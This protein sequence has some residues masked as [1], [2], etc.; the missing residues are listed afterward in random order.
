MGELSEFAQGLSSFLSR[1]RSSLEHSTREKLEQTRLFGRP[2]RADPLSAGFQTN[3]RQG[4]TDEMKT[5]DEIRVLVVDDEEPARKALG[6]ILSAGG[7]SVALAADGS[8]VRH[9]LDSGSFAV[10]VADIRLPGESG[11]DLVRHVLAEY[12]DIAALM[13]TAV[14]DPGMAEIA[15]AAGAY[16]YLVKPFKQTELLINVANAVRRRTLE[17][18]NRRHLDQLEAAVHERTVQLEESVM[19]LTD[20]ERIRSDFVS[21]ISHELR[22]P[23]TPIIGWASIMQRTPS[24]STAQVQEYGEAIH[25]NAQKLHQLVE[26]VLRFASVEKE[27]TAVQPR[28]VEV[29]SLLTDAARSARVRGHEVEV[30]VAPETNWAALDPKILEPAL[31][32]LLD[33]AAKF[34]P[35][36]SPIRLQAERLPNDLVIKVIDHGRG[37][38]EE[39]KARVFQPLVQ[40]DSSSTRRFG[41]IG[42]GL[43]VTQRL[44][45]A[46]G[47]EISLDQTPGGGATFVLSIPQRRSSDRTRLA[48]RSGLDH[49]TSE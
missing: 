10:L 18:E 29:R 25:R 23:L 41:G 39:Q 22:T 44:I 27:E 30:S 5:S 45:A 2:G 31:E 35:N 43:C 1:S 46:H 19:Q 11:I 24:L 14:D 26:S 36:G 3:K 4:G 16:G 37:V 15:L 17:I 33:N 6:R 42:L 48:S 28:R 12:P 7:Y 8:E 40:G 21:N 49:R 20:A 32:N 9:L 38:T 47:G 34:S 13:V